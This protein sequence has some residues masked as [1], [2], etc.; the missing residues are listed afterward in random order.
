M[1]QLYTT[2]VWLLRGAAAGTPVIFCE[3]M[4]LEEGGLSTALAS[5]AELWELLRTHTLPIVRA[6]ACED[7]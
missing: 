6:V 4:A 1:E 7:S 3:G 5:F 2:E